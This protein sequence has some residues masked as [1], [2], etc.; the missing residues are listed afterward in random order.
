MYAIISHGGRQFRVEKGA[1]VE[2][3]RVQAKVGE[4]VTL[5]PVLLVGGDKPLV[6]PDA[7]KGASV[8]ATVVAHTRGPKQDAMK[9][10][11]KKHYRRRLGSREDRTRVRIAEIVV[12]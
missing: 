7:L 5:G 10:K 1:V 8:T 9:Y 11:P 3:N 12:P 2:L 4:S 6:A